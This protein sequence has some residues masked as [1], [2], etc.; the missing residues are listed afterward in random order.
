LVSCIHGIKI[1]RKYHLVHPADRD[2]HP[3][4]AR[5]RRMPSKRDR[6]GHIVAA[7]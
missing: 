1:G 3:A 2:I 4:P 6:F 5:F 7:S